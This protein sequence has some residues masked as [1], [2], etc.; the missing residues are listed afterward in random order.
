[1]PAVG[2]GW[3]LPGLPSREGRQREAFG[4]AW[5]A[6]VSGHQQWHSPGRGGQGH[7]LAPDLASIIW[8]SPGPRG[9][10][11]T[12]LE[13]EGAPR[14]PPDPPSVVPREAEAGLVASGGT[15]VGS[16]PGPSQGGP[17]WTHMWTGIGPLRNPSTRAGRCPLP[18]PG[19]PEDCCFSSHL[20]HH[21]RQRRWGWSPPALPSVSP[22]LSG[23]C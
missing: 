12:S 19:P 17:A 6:R 2:P 11:Q 9:G 18:F 20:C 8:E 3:W 5:E 10:V 16:R 4:L 14:G 15:L 1:M 21:Q 7:L 23:W 22:G 13:M